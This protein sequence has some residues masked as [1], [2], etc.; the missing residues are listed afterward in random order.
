MKAVRDSNEPLDDPHRTESSVRAEDREEER[1]CER[2][3]ERGECT[4]DVG[5]AAQPKN[6][7]QVEVQYFFWKIFITVSNC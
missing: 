1:Q 7:V 6:I 5:I 2:E 3:G 4:A